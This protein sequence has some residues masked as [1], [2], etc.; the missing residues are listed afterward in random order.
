MGYIADAIVD[1]DP[2]VYDA[3]RDGEQMREQRRASRRGSC[4][5]PGQHVPG[6]G[7]G[8][9]GR[10]RFVIDELRLTWRTHRDRHTERGEKE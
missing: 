6:C 8:P 10:L 3:N 7:T 1:R 4:P 5:A 9:A 2:L